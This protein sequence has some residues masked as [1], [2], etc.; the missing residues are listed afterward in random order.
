M[1]EV[2]EPATP[3]MPDEPTTT[4]DVLPEPVNE[5][6]LEDETPRKRPRSDKNS[7]TVEKKAEEVDSADEFES[8]PTLEEQ[9]CKS[10]GID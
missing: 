10:V 4:N 9:V 8:A 2:P 7:S 6:A 3:A 1:S 5:P